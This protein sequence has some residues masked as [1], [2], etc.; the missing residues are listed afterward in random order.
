MLR[1]TRA[2]DIVRGP[3]PNEPSDLWTVFYPNHTT[4]EAL[5]MATPYHEGGETEFHSPPGTSNIPL[6]T[7]VQV[8]IYE[9]R[10]FF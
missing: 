5:S 6:I 4:Y 2:G 10:L 1:L 9:N 7:A 8:K 3:L